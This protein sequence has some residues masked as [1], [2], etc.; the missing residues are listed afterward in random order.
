MANPP[1]HDAHSTP[2][3]DNMR[4]AS[5]QAAPALLEAWTANLGRLLRDRG[6]LTLILPAGQLG[7]A[8]RALHEAGFGA[9]NLFPL[10]PHKGDEARLMLVQGVKSARGTDA[11]RPGLALH[12]DHGLTEDAQSILRDGQALRW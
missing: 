9:L 8:A 1:W 7:L 10:W 4:R 6:T 11:I 2:S 3:P 12:D 5:K